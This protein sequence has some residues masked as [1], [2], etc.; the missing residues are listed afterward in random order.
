MKNL[1]F[2]AL[3]LSLLALF[4]T[5]LFLEMNHTTP[6]RVENSQAGDNANKPEDAVMHLTLQA[7]F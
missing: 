2:P 7:L 3:V 4:P 1:V 5:V 6:V